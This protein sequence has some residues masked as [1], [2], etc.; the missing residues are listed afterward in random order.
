MDHTS[1]VGEFAVRSDE[2][3]ARNGLAKD[4]DPEDVAD[5]LLRLSIDIWVDEGDVVVAG[6]AVTEGG[7][8]LV[9]AL[10]DYLVRK[11]VSHVLEL[12]VGGRVG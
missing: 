4:L 8:S 1:L 2:D 3:L 6:D 5:E 11:R 9:D 12:L 10:D 7:E